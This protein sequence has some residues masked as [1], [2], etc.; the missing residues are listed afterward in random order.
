MLGR[1]YGDLRGEKVLVLGIKVRLVCS[2]CSW[3]N[4]GQRQAPKSSVK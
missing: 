2:S 3:Q 4:L 1:P